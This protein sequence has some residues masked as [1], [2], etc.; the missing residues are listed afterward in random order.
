MSGGR[1]R[2]GRGSEMPDGAIPDLEVHVGLIGCKA[3]GAQARHADALLQ[4]AAGGGHEAGQGQGDAQ[5]WGG[6]VPVVP[7][8]ACG[9]G[10]W[11]RPG[12]TATCSVPGG[13]DPHPLG[14]GGRDPSTPRSRGHSLSREHSSTASTAGP[15]SSFPPRL[16]RLMAAFSSC[17]R[18][19]RCS[20]PKPGVT[21]VL[22]RSARA[23]GGQ[24]EG[25][26]RSGPLTRGRRRVEIGC[27]AMDVAADRD[28]LISDPE[29]TEN[30]HGVVGRRGRPIQGPR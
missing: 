6:A 29:G 9:R 15:V 8:H 10:G 3:W 18:P 30:G 26:S 22:V 5:E 4:E 23:T 24:G 11:H 12:G 19:L 21:G 7:E 14:P 2:L 25:S 1:Q 17:C 20:G 16:S 28:A 13:W 27:K